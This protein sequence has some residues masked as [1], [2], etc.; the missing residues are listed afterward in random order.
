MQYIKTCNNRPKI[1]MIK[2]N[3]T[4]TGKRYGIRSKLTIKT[5][6]P[7]PWHRSDIFIVIFEHISHLLRL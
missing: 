5:S 4:N 2:V 6:K 3:K 1:Y 7:R